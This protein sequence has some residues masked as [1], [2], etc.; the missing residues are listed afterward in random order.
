[1]IIFACGA[2]GGVLE[3]LILGCAWLLGPAGIAMMIRLL[4]PLRLRRR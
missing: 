1:M 2:C 4:R 3:Q